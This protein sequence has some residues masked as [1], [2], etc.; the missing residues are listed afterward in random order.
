VAVHAGG[1]GALEAALKTAG[2]PFAK[3]GTVTNGDIM[4]DGESWG[5]SMDWQ[6][7]Y[8]NAIAALLAGHE[9]EAALS[10]I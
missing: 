6:A 10:A 4:I 8:D 5:S 7:R 9:S 3:L 2:T 1:A